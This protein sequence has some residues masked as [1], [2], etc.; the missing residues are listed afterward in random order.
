[1]MLIISWLAM[2]TLMFSSIT[3]DVI[4]GHIQ[5]PWEDSLGMRYWY[6]WVDGKDDHLCGTTTLAG[7]PSAK[8]VDI[9]PRFAIPCLNHKGDG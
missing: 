5:Q 3:Y 8:V 7:M 2:L 9:R 4:R 1:M 6:A